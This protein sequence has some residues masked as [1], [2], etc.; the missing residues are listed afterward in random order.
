MK[1]G[2]THITAVGDQ[3]GGSALLAAAAE[4]RSINSLI[5]LTPHLSNNGL[6]VST[7]LLEQIG[8]R[9]M[10]LAAG[11]DDGKSV[12]A[13]TLMESKIGASARVEIVSDGGAGISML[14][15]APHF[16]SL[17]VEWIGQPGDAQNEG[18][19]QGEDRLKKASDVDKIETTGTRFTD[20]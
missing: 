3:L 15:R 2:A 10:L 11:I 20:R 18:Q 1:N 12:K 6:K 14:N 8:S 9:P 19:L 5:L 4:T 7:A 17:V 13:A 16:E